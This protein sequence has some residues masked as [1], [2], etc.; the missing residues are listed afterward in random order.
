MLAVSKGSTQCEQLHNQQY[1]IYGWLHLGKLKYVT[2][3]STLDAITA[4]AGH[5]RHMI[6]V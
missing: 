6:S 5:I 1:A 4:E 3:Q 2:D